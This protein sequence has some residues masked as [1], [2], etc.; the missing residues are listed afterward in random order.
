MPPPCGCVNE[1]LKWGPPPTLYNTG[2][3]ISAES[4]IETFSE[5]RNIV[6]V[7]KEGTILDRN[8]LKLNPAKDPG[9]RPIGGM[10]APGTE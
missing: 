10:E 6:A 5:T 9:Y 3:A 2:V 8:K 4:P 7:I 1:L